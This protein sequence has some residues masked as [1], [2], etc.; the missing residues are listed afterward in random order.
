MIK[1]IY[2]ILA[3]VMVI[4]SAVSSIPYFTKDTIETI[5][6]KKQKELSSHGIDI[7]VVSNTGYFNST[8]EITIKFTDKK[9]VLRYF[10]NR[11]QI[12]KSLLT[13]ITQDEK[14]FEQIS[15]KGILKNKNTLPHKIESFL[16]IDK[17]P[18]NLQ[19]QI[20][21][22]KIL[23]KLMNSLSLQLN[24]DIFGVVNYINLNDIVIANKVITEQLT[25][26][27]LDNNLIV[28]GEV[29]K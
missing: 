5:I 26:D 11:L 29:I 8:R 18:E 21:N 22:N 9:K 1:V 24:F 16:M 7:R 12:E 25:V 20:A 13:T 3:I 6:V 28:N 23:E 14:S 17:L 10:E 27:F 4:G 15:F 2:V 19:E